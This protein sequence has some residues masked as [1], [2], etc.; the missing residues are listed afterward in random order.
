MRSTWQSGEALATICMALGN[1]NRDQFSAVLVDLI[2][3][4]QHFQSPSELVECAMVAGQGSS[5][6]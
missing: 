1:P 5:T 4:K 6:E 3:R 2:L